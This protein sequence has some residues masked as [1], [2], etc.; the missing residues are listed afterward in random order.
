MAKIPTNIYDGE[1][2]SS[3]KVLKW[4]TEN[5]QN[6]NVHFC[7]QNKQQLSLHI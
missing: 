1:F 6:H 2:C 3:R 4:K 7:G 5:I